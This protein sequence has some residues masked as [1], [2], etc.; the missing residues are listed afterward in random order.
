MYLNLW[1][2]KSDKHFLLIKIY[3]FHKKKTQT[4]YFDD[5]T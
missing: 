1:S 2:K 5:Y 3:N 4:K